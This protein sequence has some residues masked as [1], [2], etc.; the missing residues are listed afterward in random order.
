MLPD[1]VILQVS[2]TLSVDTNGLSIAWEV[3]AVV[4]PDEIERRIATGHDK[5][6]QWLPPLEQSQHHTV[7]ARILGVEKGSD[8]RQIKQDF[9]TQ[10]S[11][12]GNIAISRAR[13]AWGRQI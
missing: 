12:A 11:A 1:G 2:A 6:T 13:A 10:S 4:D 3:E 7:S 9:E 8:L 5:P